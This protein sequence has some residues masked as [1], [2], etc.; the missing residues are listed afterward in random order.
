MKTKAVVLKSILYCYVLHLYW[1]QRS[2]AK[3]IFSQACVKN[4]VHGGGFCLSA[5]WDATPPSS[6]PGANTPPGSRPPGPDPPPWE[7]T[8]LSRPP[9]ADPPRSRP[10]RPDPRDQKRPPHTRPPPPPDPP[11]PRDQTLPRSRHQHTVNERPVHI[12]L[13]CILVAYFFHHNILV[14]LI[15]KILQNEFHN[16]L[17]HYQILARDLSC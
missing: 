13:E 16:K 15:I 5:C 17:I 4:S 14:C 8:P 9:Q 6:P 3:V 11:H 12:L 1:P 7:Q 10:P 2:W